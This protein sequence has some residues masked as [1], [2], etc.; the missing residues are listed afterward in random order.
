MSGID[1]IILLLTYL[2][3]FFSL[4]AFI[5]EIFFRTD[6]VFFALFSGIVTTIL[7]ALML[8]IRPRDPSDNKPDPTSS[9]TTATVT[10]VE[11]T[12]PSQNS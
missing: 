1:P 7:G 3:I 11:E 6:S 5:A 9:K 2:L 10:T 8:R 4:L 12:K